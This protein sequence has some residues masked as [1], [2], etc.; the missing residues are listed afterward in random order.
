MCPSHAGSDVN[1]DVFVAQKCSHGTSHRGQN[2]LSLLKN[3]S[4]LHYS[5]E[6]IVPR[7][8]KRYLEFLNSC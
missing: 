2:F 1:G 8:A 4:F 3:F 6:L 7:E 5:P